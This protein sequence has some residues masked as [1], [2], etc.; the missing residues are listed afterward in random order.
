MEVV[1]FGFIPF[2]DTEIITYELVGTQI[3]QV[4]NFLSGTSF[5]RQVCYHCCVVMCFRGCHAKQ[6]GSQPDICH[7][8][9]ISVLR[10]GNLESRVIIFVLCYTRRSLIYDWCLM[11]WWL[12]WYCY[13]RLTA[14]V[15]MIILF[16]TVSDH[17]D[18]SCGRWKCPF[19]PE[20]FAVFSDYCCF[21]YNTE[22]ELFG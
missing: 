18:F 11:L 20:K 12:V 19:Y 10:T 15:E 13:Q 8:W 22:A 14:E 16:V 3:L 9:V 7:H 17:T 6:R 1:C 2:Q 21:Y 4:S 5:C